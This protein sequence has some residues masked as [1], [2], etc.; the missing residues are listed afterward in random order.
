MRSSTGIRRLFAAALGTGIIIATIGVAAASG[1]T[2]ATATIS[3]AEGTTIGWARFTEDSDGRLHVNVKVDGLSPGLHGIH[4][5]NVASCIAPAFT[6]AGSHH[7]PLSDL[8]GL[9]DPPGAHAGDLPNLV[10][11]AEGRGHL[12]AVS[13][14]ATLSAGPL[15]LDDADG[16]ALIIHAAEDDQQATTA[17]GNSGARIACGDVDVTD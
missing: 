7:N 2:Q 17:T 6:S 11:N 9:D 3:D 13:D 15:S 1:A 16:S 14:R 4:L 12:D 10:V 5:H 8:H